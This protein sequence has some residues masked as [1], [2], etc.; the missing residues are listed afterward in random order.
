VAGGR[1]GPRSGCVHGSGRARR[2]APYGEGFS[3][4]TA[5]WNTNPPPGPGHIQRHPGL[6]DGCLTS[7][8]LTLTHRPTHSEELSHPPSVR[9]RCRSTARGG[10]RSGRTRSSAAS[11]RAKRSQPC[12]QSC[13]S[14]TATNASMGQLPAPAPCPTREAS[15]RVTHASTGTT[16]LATDRERFLCAVDADLGAVVEDVAVGAGALAHTVHREPA[17]GVADVH[18]VG[19]VGLHQLGLGGQLGR[20]GHVAHHQEARDAHVQLASPRD[21]LGGDVGLGAVRGDAD[22]APTEGVGAIEFGD[23]ADAG[24]QAGR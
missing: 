6:I 19:A 20:L 7:T 14:A 13:R 12:F 24:Q 21:V 2:A 10:S 16:L 11:W 3:F 23:G 22:R 9:V 17:A 15:T 1:W 18:P 8:G 4:D 5:V